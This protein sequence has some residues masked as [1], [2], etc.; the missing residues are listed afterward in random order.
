M[1]SSPRWDITEGNVFTGDDGRGNPYDAS[2]PASQ[3]QGTMAQLQVLAQSH[4]EILS[5]PAIRA[6]MS[7]PAALQTALQAWQHQNGL[8]PKG[9][10]DAS[11]TLQ[12][13]DWFDRN[14]PW[15]TAGIGGALIAP[16]ALAALGVG[17]GAAGGAG[18][19][20]DAAVSGALP[21]TSIS[22]VGALPAATT[23]LS[24]ASDAGLAALP[25]TAISAAGSLPTATTGLSGAASPTVGKFFS[26]L[27]K[28]GGDISQVSG[29]SA[30]TAGAGRAQQAGIQ[31][32]QDRNAIS[33][34]NDQFQN[35]L[36]APSTLASQ[37][38]RG[39]VLAN[40][41]PAQFSGLPS[42][43]ANQMPTQ[44]GGLT[45]A[46]LGPNA[47][48]AGAALSRNALL[49]LASNQFNLPQAPSLTPLP[50]PSGLDQANA[51]IAQVGGYLNTAGDLY[52]RFGGG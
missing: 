39:D 51:G 22:A 44:S 27:G 7:N 21:S 43:I 11:G 15:I 25:S 8:D 1:R 35:N 32:A 13:T 23:G 37:A 19:A 33:L 52:K 26:N 31:Q 49:K 48:N 4:P 5:D 3:A 17:G 40:V 16:A 50:T 29:S 34:Y 24:A 14:L 38:V 2:T 45:P 20:T 6:A 30:A 46:M 47:R 36:K 9:V 12:D 42:W 28:L 18:A 41:Q 10:Y